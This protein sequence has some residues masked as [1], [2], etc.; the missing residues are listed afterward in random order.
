MGFLNALK[1]ILGNLDTH[2]Q[3]ISADDRAKLASAWGLAESDLNAEESTSASE[4]R[5]A[6]DYDV[7]LWHRKLKSLLDKLPESREQ[8]ADFMADAQAL[9]FDTRWV[10]ET[11]RE[12]FTLLIRRCL[13][14]HVLTPGEHQKIDLARE[15]M[16]IPETEAIQI[17]DK[18]VADAEAFF[19]KSTQRSDQRP[20]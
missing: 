17:L 9:N 6:T 19:G 18:T 13:S 7:E 11:I 4:T 8:F 3:N 14:D 2:P 1:R 5:P 20:Q 10:D 16:G 12:E 15:L